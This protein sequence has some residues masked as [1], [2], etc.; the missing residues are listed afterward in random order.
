MK[1]QEVQTGANDILD[2]TMQA[3]PQALDQVVVVGYGKQKKI[4]VVG[5]V[6]TLKPE[7][8]RNPTANISNSLAGNV[9]GVIA[10]QRSGEP[11]ADASTF[12]IRGISTF[13]GAQNPLILL[14]GVEISSGDLNSLAP[15]IIE[16]VSVLKDASATAIYGTRGA[17]GVLI[18]TT[19]KVKIWKRP[20]STPV[21]NPKF[22][23]LPLRLIL[24]AV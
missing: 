9:S 22:P 13:S 12:F 20:E 4:S 7:K 1:T 23:F 8:L 17:N 14:D 6:S 24:W 18:V 11:G 21:C 2:I 10:F 19:K 5:A 3:D 15:E 16:S